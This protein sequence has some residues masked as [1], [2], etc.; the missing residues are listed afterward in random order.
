MPPISTV[1]EGAPLPWKLDGFGVGKMWRSEGLD[2]YVLRGVAFP[3][4]SG[5]RPFSQGG[6][7]LAVLISIKSWLVCQGMVGDV[8]CGFRTCCMLSDTSLRTCS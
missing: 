1:T 7:C 6:A 4:G 2:V 8:V 3:W 5:Q